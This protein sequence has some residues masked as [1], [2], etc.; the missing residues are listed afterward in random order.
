[1]C[2]YGFLSSFEMTNRFMSFRPRVLEEPSLSI[3]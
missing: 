3:Y 2:I 1:V